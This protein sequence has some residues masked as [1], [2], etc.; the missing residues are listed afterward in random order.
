MTISEALHQQICEWMEE[1][2]S[3]LRASLVDTLQVDEK[4]NASDLVTEMDRAIER[5][6]IEK[7]NTHY[8]SHRVIGEEGQAEVITDLSGIV[9][10]IDPIDGTLNFVKQK[11]NFG[12]LVGIFQDGQPLAGYI[13]DVMHHDLYV[14]RVGIGLTLNGEPFTPLPIESLQSSLAVGNVAMFT[15]NRCNSQRLLEQVLGVRAHGSAALE[16]IEVIRGQAAVYLCFALSPWDFAAG[17]AI[18]EAMG[19]KATQPD[20]S[21]LS[22][23]QKSPVIFAH[24]IVHDEVVQLLSEKKETL[25][26][27]NEYA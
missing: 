21:P 25:G 17:W 15:L 7:I 27:I 14:G 20:G 13:Y 6:F 24:P 8:P 5:L 3:L 16:I 2:A 19:F 18:C 23:L 9:W 1:A 12:I 10:V 26:E 4:T 11:N 22:I